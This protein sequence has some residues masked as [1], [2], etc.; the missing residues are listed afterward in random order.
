MVAVTSPNTTEKPPADSVVPERKQHDLRG[1]TRVP[2]ANFALC[3]AFLFLALLAA[4]F[5]WVSPMGAAVFATVAGALIALADAMY[6]R[7]MDRTIATLSAALADSGREVNDLSSE[8]VLPESSPVKGIS[9]LIAER[10]GKVREMVY[11]VR[12]GTLSAA[13][14]AAS[15]ASGLKDTFKLAEQQQR[16]AEQVFAAGEEGKLAVE[17]ARQVSHSLDA[18][19]SRHVVAAR[20][21]L[22]ELQA[23]AHGVSDIERRLAEF[24]Q[25]VVHLEEHANEI[26]KVVAMIRGI[27]EQTNLLALNA[28]IE[29]ARAGESG[30]GFAVVADEVRSLA[31]QVNKAT[32][33][34]V[35]NIDHMGALVSDTRNEST[36]IH[37]HVRTT[38]ESV[39][40]ASNRFETMVADFAAM[41]QQIG[42]ASQAIQSLGENNVQTITLVSQ[43]H[44]SCDEVAKRMLEGGR[45]VARVSQANERIQ[46]FASSFR[47]GS[48]QME[49]IMSALESC[50]DACQEK[51]VL[52]A[53]LAGDQ[54]AETQL[55]QIQ[56]KLEPMVKKLASNLLGNQRYAQ[57]V[58]RDG[59]VVAQ[60]GTL[61]EDP[62]MTRRTLENERP[63]LLQTG[64]SGQ[65]AVYI[66]VSMPIE[67]AHR[68]WGTLRIG[69][70]ASTV[71]N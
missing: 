49:D 24:D 53:Q 5:G 56:P 51:L 22:D 28:S 45:N 19:T 27:S 59:R 44:E 3:S 23:S 29:A 18:A 37:Q 15:L 13:C 67:I 35:E 40:R 57:L 1:T 61:H 12:R 8:F 55:K 58:K 42:Q 60:V 62:D 64:V 30:R 43:I 6:I 39:R 46:E 69:F 16:L 11:R 63:L 25:T 9:K 68:P 52:A 50:R 48:D 71:L 34:I 26:G 70:P 65:G 14:Q 21:S 66:D 47:V 36:V 17:S 10:D 7:Q 20:S 4:W 32:H 33:Q 54:D 31:E 38:A 2:L 41:S